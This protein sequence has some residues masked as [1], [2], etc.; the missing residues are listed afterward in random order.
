M[1]S[2]QRGQS[3]GGASAATV[4]AANAPQCEQNFA[5][6]NIIPK[7][8]GQE[9]VANR[10]P[11]CS[12]FVASV[13]ADAPHMGQLSVSASTGEIVRHAVPNVQAKI[14]PLLLHH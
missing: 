7:Q 4:R 9:I 10:A 14:A 8:D 5:P 11:Q 12:H 6:R 13:E 1:F 3:S 2:R